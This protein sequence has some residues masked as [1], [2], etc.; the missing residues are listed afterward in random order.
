MSKTQYERDASAPATPTLPE[1][2]RRQGLTRRGFLA[3]CGSG[4]L[5]ASLALLGCG[6]QDT[7]ASQ[8]GTA[9]GS[10]GK[11]VRIGFSGEAGSDT[12]IDSGAIAQKEGFLKAELDKA[13]YTFE[14]LGFTGGSAVN[15]A[16]NSKAIDVVVYGDLPGYTGRAQGL[17]IRAFATTN[18]QL[19]CGILASEASGVSSVTDLKGKKVVVPT[20]TVLQKYFLD[21]L[22]A[23]G[24]SPADVA[25][26]NAIQDGP[27]MLT[28]GQV[29]ALVS[30]LSP[31]ELYLQKLPGSKVV[32]SSV[33]NPSIATMS[34]FYGRSEFLD[35]NGEVA[36]A[37]VRALRQSHEFA[38]SNPDKA[39]QDLATK[40]MDAS[41]IKQAYPDGTFASFDPQIGD[42]VRKKFEN[43]ATFAKD[44]K[45]V[46]KDVDLSTFLD[47][48]FY[49]NA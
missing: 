22:A 41:I 21:E 31:I 17:D 4:A 12:L 24:I 1:Q 18:S 11:H 10:Q 28:S 48:S 44:N 43:M 25:Q 3:A 23:A 32:A 36:K 19:H 7:P 27:T 13:G 37:I 6:A 40:T 46:N 15:E 45:L 39:W 2:D 14:I 5:L 20:G 26:V 47:T 9:Q 30:T 38:A 16:L 34:L 33:T 35:Q 49:E 42:D 29:D 8:A